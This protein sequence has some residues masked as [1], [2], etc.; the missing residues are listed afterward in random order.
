LTVGLSYIII[1]ILTDRSV[2]NR[3]TLFALGS[4]LVSLSPNFGML[5]AGRSLQGL[6]AGGIF[7]VASAV[8]GDTFPPEKRGSALGLIGAVF[9]LAFII[10]PI[11][12]GILLKLFGWQSLFLVNLPIAAV[13]IALSLRFLPTTRPARRRAFDWPGMLALGVLLASL[14]FGVNQIDTRDLFASIGSLDVWPFLLATVVLLFVFARVERSAKDPV[15]RM[16]LFDSRQVILAAALSAG[17]GLGESGMV[18]MPQLA[19]VGLHMGKAQSSYML[20]PVVLAMAVGSP[21]VGRLLDRFGSKVIVFAGAALLTAGMVTLG[22]L[23]TN[24]MMFIIAGAVIGLG[25]AALLGAPVRYIML[26][27]APAS[28]RSAAQ[29]AITLFTSVG[30]LMSSAVV[31]AVAASQGGGA[32][33]Y[34]AA[35]LVIGGVS[36]ALTLVTLGL[37]GRAEELA[38]QQRNEAANA[39]TVKQPAG[40]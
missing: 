2:T 25:L 36:L 23:A 9:G 24:T 29:G 31:G 4:L 22:G 1:T 13:V 18:F 39:A 32:A 8:I 15:L 11:L 21:I 26:N 16:S 6:G 28:D 7:P 14:S 5:L 20:M 38:T 19:V 40:S 34:N 27:E 17:A 33:G 3:K 37:K 30:Q 12:G 10:G 35:F